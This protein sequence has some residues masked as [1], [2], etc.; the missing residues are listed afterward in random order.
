MSSSTREKIIE[1]LGHGVSQTVVAQAVGVSDGYVSQLLEIEEVREAVAEKK[2]GKLA[3]HIETDG[4]I[5]DSER[6]ALRLISKKLDNPLVSLSDAT[7]TFAVLNAA[8]KK[9]EI[10]A[11][12]N[13][14]GA[15]DMVTFVLPKA[16]KIMIQ[17]NTDN[18]IVEVDGKTTAPL[19][20]KALPSLQRQLAIQDRV[21]ELL[22]RQQVIHS[23]PPHVEEVR[24]KARAMDERRATAVLADITTVIDGVAVVI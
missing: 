8:R 7:K 21:K 9:S 12:G 3:A 22:D 24:E 19:P 23:V 16:A 5:E 6:K 15:V 10:G 2:S 14:A 13:N 18:Q 11:T 17:I 1:M 20:S 4:S